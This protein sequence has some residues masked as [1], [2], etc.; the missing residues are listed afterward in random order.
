MVGGLGTDR[1]FGQFGFDWATYKND[2]FGLEADMNN[3]LFAPPSL[4]A[5]P[6]AIL[7][8]YAQTE[9][10]SGSAK[11]DI[12]RGDDDRRPRR[13]R[14]DAGAIVDGLDHALYDV[15]VD[16]INGLDDLLGDIDE[17]LGDEVRF[18]G[19]NILLGGASS[20]IIEG[21]GGNDLIDGDSWLNVRIE[22]ISTGESQDT[23]AGFQQRVLAGQIPVA[24]LKIVR[25]ISRHERRS[26]Y[27]RR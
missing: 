25:E 24:D 21:R 2:P 4:P 14:G 22:R 15:N 7:D 27:R 23:M 18:S 10:L 6:G 11:S 26:R 17:R 19:G 9:A 12:L 1:F 3:R 8:R 5:S 13:R 16:L 20:D